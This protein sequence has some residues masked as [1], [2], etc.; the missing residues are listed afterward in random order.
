[1]EAL[2]RPLPATAPAAPN[3]EPSPLPPDVTAAAAGDRVAFER[4]YRAHVARVHGLCLRLLGDRHAAEE[5]TQ[6]AFVRAWRMLPGFRGEAAF[7]TWLHR[8]AVSVVLSHRRA[9]A[10]R[11]ARSGADDAAAER[12]PA[13]PEPVGD[14][15][16]LD[17]AIAR[18]P[19]GARAVFV[20]HDV[21]G[22][23][24]DEIGARLGITAGGSKAQLHRARML[25]RAALQR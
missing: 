15:L 20:L 11:G 14:R 17:A 21:E 4:L 9:A 16:D 6:D 7:G 25:L 8:V 10:I 1:M 24:H 2:L 19:A 5:A 3:R 23:T 13:R 22:F 12:A 18:L